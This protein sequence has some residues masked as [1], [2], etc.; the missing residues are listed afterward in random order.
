ML[1]YVL[2]VVVVAAVLYLSFRALGG[3]APVAAEDF[4]TVLTRISEFA[5]ARADELD[6][7]IRAGNERPR[8][9]ATREAA[10]PLVAAA[11]AARK[12][13]S[14][15]QEQLARL[16][17]DAEGEEGEVLGSARSLLSAGIEDLGWACRMLEAGNHAD[18]SGVQRAVAELCAAGRECLEAA[19]GLVR[20]PSALA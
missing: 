15:Y 6:E 4:R 10:D 11:T 5:S 9:A 13:L 17:L 1:T 20:S 19:A 14:G 18:N 12:K 3:G 7:A 8:T 2:V 16:E